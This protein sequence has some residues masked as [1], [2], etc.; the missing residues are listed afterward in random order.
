MPHEGDVR[1]WLRRSTFRCSDED[2]VIQE[3]YCRISELESAS[4]IVSGRAYFF[5]VVRNILLERLRRERVVRIDT[6]TEIELSSIEDSEPGPEQR[7]SGRQ[8]L[9]YVL[10]LIEQLPERCKAVFRLRKIEGCSQ[11]EVAEHLG[12]SENIVEKQVVLGLRLLLQKLT[13]ASPASAGRRLETLN[14]RKRNQP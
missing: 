10:Q 5:M 1:R 12:I 14:D 8:E 4:H 13:E 7:C 9:A 11:R 2:D 6:M 3:A